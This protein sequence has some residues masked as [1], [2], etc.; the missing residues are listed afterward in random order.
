MLPLLLSCFKLCPSLCL[1]ACHPICQFSRDA[2]TVRSGEEQ[3]KKKESRDE[4]GDAGAARG[5][6]VGHRRFQLKVTWPFDF[7]TCHHL[8]CL[9]PQWEAPAIHRCYTV[10]A[11]SEYLS[12]S[13][14]LP[15]HLLFLRSLFFSELQSY[16]GKETWRCDFL[17]ELRYNRQ[18]FLFSFLPA[19]LIFTLLYLC[20]L[21]VSLNEGR[22]HGTVSLEMLKRL[23]FCFV[24][25]C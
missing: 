21:S 24:L 16:G 20:V 12:V 6:S 1:P 18:C 7:V 10:L 4:R 8:P 17:E 23:F 2:E 11:L 3:K 9:T 13:F 22:C 19:L 5:K 15:L 25:R 14:L